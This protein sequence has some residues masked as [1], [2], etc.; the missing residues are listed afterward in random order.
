MQDAARG[1]WLAAFL[2]AVSLWY[3]VAMSSKGFY[4]AQVLPPDFVL[5]IGA[6]FAVC[7]WCGDPWAGAFLAYVIVRMFFTP[8]IGGLNRPTWATIGL[9]IYACARSVRPQWMRSVRWTAVGVAAVESVWL[10]GFAFH[11]WPFA[12]WRWSGATMGNANF[13]AAFIAIASPW[14]PAWLLVLL[15]LGVLASKSALGALAF[16]AAVCLRWRCQAWVLSLAAVIAAGTVWWRGVDT[17]SVALRAAIWRWGLA[18]WFHDGLVFGK[19]IGAWTVLQPGIAQADN[20]FLRAHNEFLQL[21]F[22]GGLVALALVALWVWS[23]RASWRRPEA[24]ALLAAIGIESFG[25]FPFHVP[26]V[27]VLALIALGDATRGEP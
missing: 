26:G 24:A 9:G 15:G 20:P 27:A 19:G 23:H 17:T 2:A 1:L 7:V 16:S 13:A 21:G 25:M 5:L 18:T 8:Q 14:A 12:W 11:R 4:L 3:A 10:I 22:D 6:L